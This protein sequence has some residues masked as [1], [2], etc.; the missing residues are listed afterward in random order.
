MW[1][2]VRVLRSQKISSN[3]TQGPSTPYAL[4]STLMKRALLLLVL[5]LSFLAALALSPGELE[6]LEVLSADFPA[7]ARVHDFDSIP[8]TGNLSA[9]CDVPSFYGLKC[10]NEPDPHIQALY[11]QN[12]FFP[13]V[14][15]IFSLF[16]P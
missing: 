16:C 4:P 14:G 10:S 12:N 6:A 15:R 2:V 7:L 11:V 9:A 5:S 8:W 1:W 13:A 3:S